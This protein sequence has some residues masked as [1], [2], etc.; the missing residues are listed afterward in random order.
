[1]QAPATYRSWHLDS[2]VEHSGIGSRVSSP[3]RQYYLSL[4]NAMR[5]LVN[6]SIRHDRVRSGFRVPKVNYFQLSLTICVHSSE[7]GLRHE[8]R[9]SAARFR[10]SCTTGDGINF[11]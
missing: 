7:P 6:C 3:S 5:E 2:S 10:Y 8:I 9:N 1:M 4:Q 11:K